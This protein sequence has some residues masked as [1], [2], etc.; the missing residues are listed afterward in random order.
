MNDP[1]FPLLKDVPFSF[2]P[3]F[4]LDHAGHIMTDPR[5]ALV[6]LVANSYDAGSSQ[7][8]IT[9]PEETGG[10]L[11]ILD[12]G[13]G[14]T[15]AEFRKRWKTFSYSR[16]L[17]QGIYVDYPPGQ[18]G[19]A[20]REAFG[21][22]GKGRYAPF[23]FADAYE[24]ETWKGGTRIVMRVTLTHGGTEPFHCE[25]VSEDKKAGHGTTVR[26][27]IQRN[28]LS[29]EAVADA[30]GSKFT[31]DPFVTIMLNGQKIQ[32]LSLPG[33]TTT[34]LMIEPYGEVVIHQIGGSAQDR[35]TQ[36]RGITWWV[37]GRMVGSPS[38]EGLD[39]CGAILDGRTAMA[40]RY[41][42][43]VEANL[44]KK[45]V[46]DD[47]M[48]FH[49]SPASVAVMDAVRKHVIEALSKLLA[50]NRR[51]KKREALA[52]SRAVLDRL[53]TLSKRIVSSFVDEVLQKCPT[54]SHGDLI[55]TVKILS[56]LEKARS[57]Y[58]LLE[59][60][61]ACDP[62][63]LDTWNRLM[64]EW[65]ASGAE[66][67]LSELKGRL[68]LIQRLQALVNTTSTD[69]L[70]EL[71][72]LFARGLWIFGPE[73]ESVEFTSNR[74]MVTVIRQHL[75]GSAD[76]ISMRR[77]DFVALSDRSIGVYSADHFDNDGEVDGIRKV[78]VVELKKGGFTI[79]PDELHQGERYASELLRAKHISRSTEIVVFVLGANLS[80]DAVDEHTV[81]KATKIIPMIY[82]TI[83]KR[84][85]A[86]TF[87]LQRK[88]EAAFPTRPQN[89]DVEESLPTPLFAT[90]ADSPAE[91]PR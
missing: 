76:E 14:M 66:I 77:P 88:L 36:L 19:P 30:I 63:D 11:E 22:H 48:G 64:E 35:T 80:D 70:H 62:K 24:V 50:S 6:E 83:L 12:N 41:S 81:G 18:Q 29:E 72:P 43:V 47:W 68:D 75:G 40:K 16:P 10:T 15:A 74:A 3:K 71:Q 9:W 54:L 21:Q 69:E 7:V 89:E 56:T 57:G 52:E 25:V 78:L 34:P 28:K 39:D 79:T 86:R 58:E 87:N 85:H 8:K 1:Q 31:V 26:T 55:R 65:S 44:L 53:P 90:D 37:K 4:L 49:D 17:E 38:W 60:L 20:K 61:A 73:Y 13:T 51:E 5:I 91:A 84:A 33:I 2:G 59:K 45:E 32:L 67:V 23:C 82:D 46:K 42:F 27:V